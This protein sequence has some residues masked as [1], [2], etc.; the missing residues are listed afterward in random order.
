NYSTLN[1]VSELDP[2]TTLINS[3]QNNVNLK[4]GNVPGGSGSG[5][6]VPKYFHDL[7]QNIKNPDIDVYLYGETNL[8]ER[9]FENKLGGTFPNIIVHTHEYGHVWDILTS[10]NSKRNF[11]QIISLSPGISNSE[12]NA[13]YWENI[14][15]GLNNMSLR[16]FYH[17]N[18]KNGLYELPANITYGRV[19]IRHNTKLK[20]GK[21]IGLPPTFIQSIILENFD[22]NQSFEFKR[23]IQ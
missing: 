13:M 10:N 20:N 21:I 8:N 22:K 7:S 23:K 6:N 12:V 17:Y 18:D 19:S 16:K 1:S 11:Q 2:M 15:R 5:V 4:S 3:S 9:L 14:F